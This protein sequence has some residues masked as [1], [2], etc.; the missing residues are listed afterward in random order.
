MGAM[1]DTRTYQEVIE[2]LFSFAG[3]ELESRRI[4]RDLRR[5]NELDNEE[6]VK[7]ANTM[8]RKIGSLNGRRTKR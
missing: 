6:R 4:A 2:D 8:F 3:N 5:L 7:A 1:K